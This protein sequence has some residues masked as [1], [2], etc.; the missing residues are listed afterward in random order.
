MDRKVRGDLALVFCSLIWGVAFVVVKDVL[1]RSSVFLFLAMRFSVA[2]ALMIAFQS[3]VLRSMER[4]EVYAGMRLAFFMFAG[5]AFQTTGLLYTS[6]ANSAF[7]TGSSVVLVPLLLAIFWGKRLT[8]WMY[9]GAFAALIGLYF[10]TVPAQGLRYLNHGDMLTF[11]GAGLYAVHI[12]LVS[13][14][15]QQHSVSSLSVIQVAGC[16]GMAWVLTFGA[17][18]THRQPLRFEWGWRLAFG[19]VICAVFA[20]AIAFTLQLWAQRDSSASHA[21][22]I[23]ALE[24]VFA[25]VAAYVFLRERLTGRGLVGA[26]F[27]VAGIMIA[28]MLGPPAAPE[29]AEP[30][31][32]GRIYFEPWWRV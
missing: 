10:L 29:A 2:V 7:V 28:E 32:E 30:V 22:I 17:A 11:V 6:A 16:A 12:I 25:M 19:I 27:V 8:H 26:V 21:A 31:F 3:K 13:E 15:T 23:F 24:P 14:Y 5:Y 1:D 9:G 20:T 18:A 4:D